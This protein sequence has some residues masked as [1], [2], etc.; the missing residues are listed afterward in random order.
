MKILLVD[1]HM[2]VREGVRRLLSDMEGVHIFVA[3]S[4][5]AAL[6]LFA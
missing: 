2:V 3:A 4:C 1:D 6:A 5:E